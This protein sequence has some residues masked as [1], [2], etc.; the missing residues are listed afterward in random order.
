MSIKYMYSLEIFLFP[1]DSVIKVNDRN[2]A[3]FPLN[4]IVFSVNISC[5]ASHTHVEEIWQILL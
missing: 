3:L 4:M 1:R 2:K 5:I